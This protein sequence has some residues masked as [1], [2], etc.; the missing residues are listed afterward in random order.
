MRPALP[1]QNKN[2]K[3]AQFSLRRQNVQMNA[4][5]TMTVSNE[6]PPRNI[7]DLLTIDNIN[8]NTDAI[9][10]II[11]NSNSFSKSFK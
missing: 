7:L 8:R 6:E 9:A 11:D 10:R 3:N 1:Q 5:A 2:I 4:S